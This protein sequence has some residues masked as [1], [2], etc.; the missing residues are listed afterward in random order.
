MQRIIF[1][2]IC[3]LFFFLSLHTNGQVITGVIFDQKTKITLP[4]A[5]IYQDGTT[6]V[7]ISDADGS[8]SLDVKGLNSPLMVR[9]M[10]YDTKKI[11]QPL[12]YQGKKLSVFLKEQSFDLAEVVVRR[13]LFT[14]R[15][16]LLAFKREFL[17]TSRSAER[18]IIINEDDILLKYDARKKKLIANA[19]QPLQIINNYLEY[20]ISFDLIELVVTYNSTESLNAN[21]VANSSFSGSS[22]Y[23]D[24]AKIKK[25]DKKRLDTYRGSTKHFIRALAYGNLGEELWEIYVNDL[26]I[27]PIN[28]FEISDSLQYKKIKLIKKPELSANTKSN[29]KYSSKASTISTSAE[30]E[31]DEKPLYFVPFYFWKEQSLMEFLETA[32]Y[33]DGNGNYFPIFGIGF[34][35][36][37]AALRAGDL[38]PIDYYQTIKE[39]QNAKKSR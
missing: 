12:Q 3:L 17:G 7:T 36:S 13:N 35:G 2:T 39:N 14:R 5:T 26:K 22:F 6:N 24:F 11:D 31:S 21:L 1:K 4:G 37:L 18:C 25:A 23:T 32:I 33:V 10:S 19:R 9:F 29:E 8:F 28:Y 34:G 20:E 30:S 15:E 38:L 16:M 27:D